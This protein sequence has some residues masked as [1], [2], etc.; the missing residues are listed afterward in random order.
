VTKD[1]WRRHEGAGLGI[2]ISKRFIELHGGQMWVES[3]PG[4]GS[5]FY[6]TIPMNAVADA[7]SWIN[8]EREERYWQAMQDRAEK[9]KHILTVSTDPAAGEIIAPYAARPGG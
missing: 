8:N 1:S 2:P 5:H 4:K 9:E 7:A 6:F 3:A